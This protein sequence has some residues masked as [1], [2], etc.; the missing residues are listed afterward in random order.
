MTF[1][2]VGNVT[3]PTDE[4]HNF[5]EGLKPP[6]KWDLPSGKQW[7]NHGIIFWDMMANDN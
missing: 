6:T 7:D 1:H 2:S 3:I 4:L 5:S